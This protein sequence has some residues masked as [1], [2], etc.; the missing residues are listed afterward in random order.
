MLHK[1]NKVTMNIFHRFWPKMGTKNLEHVWSVFQNPCFN[2]TQKLTENNNIFI[3][4]YIGT[5]INPLEQQVLPYLQSLLLAV[6]Q[7]PLPLI[8]IAVKILHP[9][10]LQKTAFNMLI[11]T[12]VHSCK[13]PG[14]GYYPVQPPYPL[15][16]HTQ[17]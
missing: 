9:L 3:S 15:P 7:L 1:N 10:D 5:K 4:L 8:I 6:Q 13:I 17:Q 11:W 12:T 16:L 14:T 2:V